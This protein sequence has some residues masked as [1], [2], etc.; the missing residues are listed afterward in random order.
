MA[1]K[2]CC[3]TVN[4]KD[5][6]LIIAL[7]STMVAVMGITTSMLALHDILSL[8]D[9]L[10]HWLFHGM[11][12]LG[13]YGTVFHCIF[14]ALS[15]LL[16]YA[17][18]K[19]VLACMIPWLL[20]FP[21]GAGSIVYKIIQVVLLGGNIV[22]PVVSFS[23]MIL[24]LYIYAVMVVFSYYQHFGRTHPDQRIRLRQNL[25]CFTSLTKS[26]KDPSDIRVEYSSEPCS[27][28]RNSGEDADDTMKRTLQDSYNRT[29]YCSPTPRPDI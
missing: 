5:A 11:L 24:S 17:T 19:D 22:L 29:R 1:L 7:V 8:K 15:L 14:L 18:V 16:A 25:T 27:S 6:S 28:L 23:C 10:F 4:L 20:L 21:L 13:T 2:D 12:F 26:R 9:I 3:F